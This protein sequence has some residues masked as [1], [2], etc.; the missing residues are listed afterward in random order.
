MKKNLLALAAL[1]MLAACSGQ[2]EPP[3]RFMLLGDLHYDLLENHDL[4]W[5]ATTDDDLRQVTTEYSVFTANFWDGFTKRLAD[6]AASLPVTAVLQQGDLSEGLAGTPELAEK[7]AR[8]VFSAIDAIGFK[9][10]VIIAK[11]NHDITGPGAPEAFDKVYLPNMARL[12]R[13]ERLESADYATQVGDALFVCYDPWGK[14]EN[15]G[16]DALERNLASSDARYKFVMVH[17]PV[18]PINE[19]CWHL[20]RRDE[21]RRERLLEIIARE[22]AIVLCAHMHLYSV[23]CRE[24]TYGP[25]LQVLVNSVV[26]DSTMLAPRHVITEYGESLVRDKPE[27]QPQTLEQRCAWL[28]AEAPHVTYF[29]QAD[30]PG[31]GILSIDKKHDRMTLEYYAA[32]ADEPYDTIDLTAVLNRKGNSSK[33]KCCIQ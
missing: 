26:R 5:L 28:A 21:A 23:V 31:Y 25:I 12:A 2:D 7:M 3:T 30:L 16:L 33:K 4:A 19:R 11:G 29:K 15:K 13:H 17:E 9:V 14:S 22:K 6:R 1:A 24:T 10:P 32:F 8:D 20:L 27:W 18:I